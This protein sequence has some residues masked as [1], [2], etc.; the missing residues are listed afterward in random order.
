MA[1]CSA[2]PLGMVTR[3]VQLLSPLR[4]HTPVWLPMGPTAMN[5]LSSEPPVLVSQHS[6]IQTQAPVQ[7][8]SVSYTI[9]GLRIAGAKAQLTF[10]D[11][12]Y[13]V[14]TL[15]GSSPASE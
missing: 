6:D 9:S 14:A 8:G 4:C 1:P 11:S 7:D 12:L 10:D 2:V 13:S 5:C 3:S 15:V